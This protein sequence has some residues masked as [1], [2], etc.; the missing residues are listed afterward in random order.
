V[1]KAEDEACGYELNKWYS[2][3]IVLSSSEIV[4]YKAENGEGMVEILR[5]TK[6]NELKFGKISLGTFKTQAAFSNIKMMPREDVNRQNII[7][8]GCLFTHFISKSLG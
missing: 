6:D 7:L 4:V 8:F 2:V 1:F 3:M 5:T